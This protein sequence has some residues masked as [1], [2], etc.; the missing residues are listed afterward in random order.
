MY[1]YSYARAYVRERV[2]KGN[3]TMCPRSSYPIHILSNY[4]KWDTTSWTYSNMTARFY[5]PTRGIGIV[6][7]INIYRIKIK[8]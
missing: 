5:T 1:V 8:I 7:Y 3:T 4:I 6:V 2:K